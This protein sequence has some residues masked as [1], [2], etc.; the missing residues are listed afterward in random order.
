VHDDQVEMYKDYIAGLRFPNKD[1]RA[2]GGE[3]K[4][5]QDEGEKMME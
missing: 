2:S 3:A 1:E 4:A 5:Q